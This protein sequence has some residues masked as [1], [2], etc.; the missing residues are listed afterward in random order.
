MDSRKGD[1]VLEEYVLTRLT[2]DFAKEICSW[3]YDGDYSVYN[4]SDWNV[5]VKNGWGLAIKDMREKEFIAVLLN[6]KLIAYGKIREDEGKAFI[7]IGLKPSWCG[8]GYGK[9]VMNLLIEECKKRFHNTPIA[10][11][12][13]SFNKRAIN[14]YKTVGFQ[15][16]DKYLK[17]TFNGEDEFYYME[18]A[19]NTIN[20]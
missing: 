4:F 11:E 12:V 15:V 9:D 1:G 7:G 2:E 5:V 16:R 3:R 8:K 14:C 17:K 20:K 10:L 18:Y 6:G 19:Y 13:R